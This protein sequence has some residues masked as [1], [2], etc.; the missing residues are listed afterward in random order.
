VASVGEQRLHP[1]TV[2][3]GAALPAQRVPGRIE[4]IHDDAVA[5][6]CGDGIARITSAL[7]ARRRR[8]PIGKLCERLE[9]RVGDVFGLPEDLA[10]AKL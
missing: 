3:R 10:T 5:V 6:Q 7:D 4:A 2:E 1:L 8:L 9:L